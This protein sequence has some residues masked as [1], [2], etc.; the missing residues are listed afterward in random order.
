V[1]II[2]GESRPSKSPEEHRALVAAIVNARLQAQAAL[3][4]IEEH[5]PTSP[6][7]F[8]VLPCVTVNRPGPDRELLVARYEVDWTGP[9]PATN[10]EGLGDDPAA[11][12]IRH[13]HGRL[14]VHDRYWPAE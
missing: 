13:K 3:R 2:G 12:Q 10:Y 14:V 4:D 6:T 9:S 1:L 8:L 5:H 11:Y 7:I